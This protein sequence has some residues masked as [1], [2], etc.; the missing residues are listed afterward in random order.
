VV[1]ECQS[2]YLC[3]YICIERERERER[4]RYKKD[5]NSDEACMVHDGE[6]QS[7]EYGTNFFFIY[8]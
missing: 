4:E 3:I 1:L 7:W 5:E 6:V 2:Q 8:M